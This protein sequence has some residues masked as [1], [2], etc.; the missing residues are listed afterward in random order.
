MINNR[1]YQTLHHSFVF[2]ELIYLKVIAQKVLYSIPE[3]EGLYLDILR[4]LFKHTN[5]EIKGNGI[6][7]QLLTH[8]TSEFLERD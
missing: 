5:I 4:M 2:I 7:A 3:N 6:Y 8:Q 1:S